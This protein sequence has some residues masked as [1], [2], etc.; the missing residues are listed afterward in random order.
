MIKRKNRSKRTSVRNIMSEI[1]VTPFVD[2]MLVLLIVFMITAP[3]LTTGVKVDLPKVNTAS[4]S[5]NIEPLIISLNKDK[6]VFISEQIVNI[7]DIDKKL[8]AV[9]LAN[10][11]IRIFIRA[12]KSTSYENLMNLM[13]KVNNAGLKKV[14]LVTLPE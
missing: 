12:D 8:E 6:E 4:L 3:L 14:S 5:D 9:R 10:P 2:V 13:K 7:N 1:N 11:E